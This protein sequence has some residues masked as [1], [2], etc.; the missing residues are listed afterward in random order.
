MKKGRENVNHNLNKEED[1]YTPEKVCQEADKMT[2]FAINFLE[3]SS[4]NTKQK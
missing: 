4:Q 1:M 3:I 2:Y